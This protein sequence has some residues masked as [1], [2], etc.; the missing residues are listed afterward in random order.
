MEVITP[1]TL[2]KEYDPSILPLN[3]SIISQT[4]KDGITIKQ[5]YFNGSAA[6]DGFV[7]VYAKLYVPQTA[8]PSV[9]L[10]MD[11][12]DIYIDDARIDKYLK[13]GYA[14]FV[15]DYAGER[16]DK[17]RFTIYPPSLQFAKYWQNDDCLS[18]IPQS[19]KQSCWYEWTVLALRSITYLENEE[20]VNANSIAMVGY[21]AGGAQVWKVCALDERVKA[22]VVVYNSGYAEPNDKTNNDY[23][24][25]KACI[26]NQS[27]APYIK[28]P[29]LEQIT[30]NEVSGSLDRMSDVFSNITNPECLISI[31][32][33]T[34]RSFGSK[35]KDNIKYFLFSKLKGDAALPKTPQ[36]SARGSDHQ[37][38][39]EIKADISFEI[40]D[41]ELF[42]AQA[43]PFGAY[44]NW[45]SH[46]LEKISENEYLCKVDCY[47]IKEPI[48]AF[49][50]IK[51]KN[52]MSISSPL[53]TKIPAMMGVDASAINSSRLI[54]D[55]DMLLDTW[56]VLNNT[57]A[58]NTLKMSGGPFDI[59]GISSSTN[60]LSTFK[61]GDKQYRGSRDNVLQLIVYSPQSQSVTLSVTENNAN[62]TEYFYTFK[63]SPSDNWAK[64]SLSASDFKS[65][66][67]TLSGWENVVKFN[68]KSESA[69]LINSMLW[70]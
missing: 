12:V 44:R 4:V 55:S 68:V 26:L 29:I 65:A 48:Y 13:K 8:A 2:W 47:T 20:L 10:L 46:K 66:D 25:Y 57:S 50:N 21:G 22:G 33:R 56:L 27:Y 53:L 34:N 62:Y 39:Y 51:Y 49:T 64:L 37:L 16:D 14:V 69:V 5:V 3:A 70:V 31:S 9:I 59:Q 67:G 19:P 32:E 42:V 18:Q 38:Y 58:E 41:V 36:L 60:S 61:V 11:E 63:A 28:A 30:S 40:E 1:L 15:V 35:Q 52:N 23:L 17:A 24:T 6:I 45:S 43:M 54:Y 7:R